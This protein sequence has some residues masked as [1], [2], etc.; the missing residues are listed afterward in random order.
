M[1]NAMPG[2]SPEYKTRLSKSGF[3]ISILE[4]K[5]SSEK[6]CGQTQF[7][8]VLKVE[9]MPGKSPE[10]KT[11]FKQ[12]GFPHFNTGRENLPVKSGSGKLRSLRG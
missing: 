8:K 1:L 10:A 7:G 11:L 2:K 5:S 3:R 4:E 12:I 6:R 9:R